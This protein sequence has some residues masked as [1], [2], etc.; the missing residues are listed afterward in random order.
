MSDLRAPFPWFGGK[1]RVAPLVWTRFGDVSSY[2]EPFAGSMACV[3]G[4]PHWPWKDNRIETVNDADCYLANFWRA[5]Q[6]DPQAVAEWADRP[7][8][9]ADLSAIHTW[10][11]NTGKERV[12]QLK[13]DPDFYDAKV[14]GWWVWG[15]CIWIGSG[16]VFR[17]CENATAFVW[18]RSRY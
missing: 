16:V 7:V 15:L 12:E 10:L 2:V 13:T 1:S 3:L 17:F 14:A 9:E 18:R 6:A 5:L 4:R 8:N 11:I